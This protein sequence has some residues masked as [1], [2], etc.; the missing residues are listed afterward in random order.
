MVSGLARCSFGLRPVC[1]LTRFRAFCTKGF[2]HFITSMPASAATG[3]SV[4]CRVGLLSPT[5]VLRLFTAHSNTLRAVF[6]TLLTLT[7]LGLSA[8]VASWCAQAAGGFLPGLVEFLI[9]Q[10][11]L[12]TYYFEH[13]NVET[14][15]L[16]IILSVVCLACLVQSFLQFRYAQAGGL[17]PFRYSGILITLT[18]ALTFVC[19]DF[20]ISARARGYQHLRDEVGIALKPFLAKRNPISPGETVTI[21]AADLE[22]QALLS[23]SV[24]RWLRGAVLEISVAKPSHDSAGRVVIGEIHF[25]NGMVDFCS[26]EITIIPS[27]L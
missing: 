12:P 16:L 7:T 4:S 25:P 26:R 19:A 24:K 27:R 23:P 1:S 8:L 18:L 22:K 17:T 11:Q 3:W 5:G 15:S 10:F 20:S 2:E 21:S 9:V 13:L 14:W 6:V